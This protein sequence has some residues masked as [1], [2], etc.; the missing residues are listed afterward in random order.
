MN[1]HIR[2]RLA[3][4]FTQTVGYRGTDCTV[5]NKQTIANL[6]SLYPERTSKICQYGGSTT[7]SCTAASQHLAW[8]HSKARLIILGDL[9]DGTLPADEREMSAAKAWESIYKHYV[10]FDKVLFTQFEKQL[11]GR[12]GSTRAQSWLASKEDPQST[13]RAEL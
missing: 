9:E 13:W 1:M 12:R 10:E 5:C 11:V 4:S 6:Y 2:H 8:R 7:R 3:L